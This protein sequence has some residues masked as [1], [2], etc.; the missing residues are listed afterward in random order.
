MY[1]HIQFSISNRFFQL[2]LM[3]F[4]LLLLKWFPT[5]RR[6]ITGSQ[7]GEFT[8]WN[9]QS[10]NFE[11]ILQVYCNNICLGM[12]FILKINFIVFFFKIYFCFRLMIK[13]L[14]P[15]YGVI[16]RIGWS[17][18][19]MVVLSSKIKNCHY[20]FAV[21]NFMSKSTFCC[22]KTHLGIGRA[23]W[24]MWRQINLPIKKQFVTWG[25]LQFIDSLHYSAEPKI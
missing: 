6:L 8:L 2:F 15:W 16:M 14:D 9:G 19:M 10:F 22:I 4:H 13:Q 24:I 12:K 1:I 7:S 18:G 20:I 21:S 11:M 3:Y 23:T 17:V 25:H 5:G